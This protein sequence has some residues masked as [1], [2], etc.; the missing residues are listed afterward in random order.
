VLTGRADLRRRARDFRDL[1]FAAIR[2][3][4]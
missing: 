4:T 3:A 1:W 2:Q